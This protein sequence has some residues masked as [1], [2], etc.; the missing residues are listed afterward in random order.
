MKDEDLPEGL[1]AMTATERTA[2]LAAKL[3]QRTALQQ[4]IQ[5]VNRQREDYVRQHAAENDRSR[6]FDFAVRK[7]VRAQAEAR[8]LQLPEAG[9]PLETPAAGGTDDC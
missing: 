2:H 7:A 6:S 5:A 9:A 4:Q 3:E 8:G 1:R